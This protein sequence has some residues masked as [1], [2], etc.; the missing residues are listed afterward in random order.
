MQTR[1]RWLDFARGIPAVSMVVAHT[2]SLALL[3]G[4]APTSA[5][6]VPPAPSSSPSRTS[7]TPEPSSSTSEAPPPIVEATLAHM[8]EFQ[9]IADGHGGN[10]ADGT[11]G[12]GASLDY[13]ERVLARAGFDTQR[14]TGQAIVD[15]SGDAAL[16]RADGRPIEGAEVLPMRGSPNTDGALTAQMVVPASTQGCDAAD[17]SEARGKAVLVERGTCAFGHKSQLARDAG[18]VAVIIHERSGGPI[19]GDLGTDDGF[20]PTISIS[21]QG[22]DTL[23]RELA[24]G[25]VEVRLTVHL[26][27]TRRPVTNLIAE[28]PGA[29]GDVVMLGAHIDGVPAGP[30]INDNASGVSLALAT[31]ERL[32][33]DGRADRFRVA[34]W[35]GEELG[36]L[37]SGVYV[38]QFGTRELDVSAYINLDMV[39]SPNGVVGIHGTGVA[40]EVIKD[41]LADDDAPFVEIAM[42]GYSDHVWFE[43]RQVPTVGFHTGAGD[44]VSPQEAQMF[45][46]D[47]GEPKDACYHKA[48]DT[49]DTAD[50]PAV[51]A[52][53]QVIADAV[54]EAIPR[55][56]G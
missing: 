32:A 45:G 35:G 53:L 43:S 33:H 36:L 1:Y 3:S 31:A 17:Y 40:L 44:T 37:G 56:R 4:C 5:P 50:R 14:Q 20:V 30:G 8:A 7:E 49:L 12:F 46:S 21:V 27:A 9:R 2:A 55:L 15:W 23:R 6:P 39:A 51:R 42:A 25:V 52:R 22:A 28:F 13:A 47:E 34:L 38:E 29:D 16:T 41:T 54:L 18:A 48:C 26:E 24:E 19:N 11:P 10:R